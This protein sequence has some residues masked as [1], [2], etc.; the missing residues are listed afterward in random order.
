MAVLVQENVKLN[1]CDVF[2]LQ[3]PISAIFGGRQNLLENWLNDNEIQL[4]PIQVLLHVICNYCLIMVV[5]VLVQE[6]AAKLNF[7]DVSGLKIVFLP[8]I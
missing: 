4:L 7:C 1:F 6:N 8:Y 2:L 3:T 5:A